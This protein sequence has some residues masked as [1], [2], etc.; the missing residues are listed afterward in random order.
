MFSKDTEK[1]ESF[2]GPNTDFRGDL[3]VNGTLKLDGR[4]DGTLKADSVILSETAF[5]KGEVTAKKIIVGGKVEGNLRAN[6]IVEIK[7]KGKVFGD[8]STG[9]FS[10]AEGGEFN[11]KIEMKMDGNKVVDFESKSR[12]V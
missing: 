9:K 7:S 10:V 1:L 3:K 12:E 6:D 5:V 2:M 8:I 11:G 4:L